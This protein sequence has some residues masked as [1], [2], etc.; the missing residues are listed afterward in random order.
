MMLL[1]IQAHVVNLILMKLAKKCIRDFK[2]SNLI[3]LIRFQ[4]EG[5]YLCTL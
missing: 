1:E 4:V 5:Q 3:G 2:Y